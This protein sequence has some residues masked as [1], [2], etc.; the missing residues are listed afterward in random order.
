MR[1]MFARLSARCSPVRCQANNGKSL[2][3]N[4]AQCTLPEMILRVRCRWDVGPANGNTSGVSSPLTADTSSPFEEEDRGEVRA[5]TT[6]D[7]P[8]PFEGEGWGEVLP[9]L[10]AR[11]QPNPIDTLRS[12][13]HGSGCAY[14]TRK[15]PQCQKSSVLCKRPVARVIMRLKQ[16]LRAA[17]LPMFGNRPGSQ[18]RVVHPLT[19]L[20]VARCDRPY[21]VTFPSLVRERQCLL[22]RQS[23]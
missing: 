23:R 6:T 13:L 17:K 15:T 12:D 21:I 11:Q 22:D 4:A 7:T 5:P 19:S 14:Y 2:P 20:T 8:S 16:A 3:I 18:I 9:M 10:T 1:R